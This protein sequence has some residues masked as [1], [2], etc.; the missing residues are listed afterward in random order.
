[1]QIWVAGNRTVVP[2]RGSLVDYKE[3]VR[4]EFEKEEAER[5]EGRKAVMEE[6]AEV[7]RIQR[8]DAQTLEQMAQK[9]ELEK[10]K[11]E[12]SANAL[13]SLLNSRKKSKTAKATKTSKQMQQ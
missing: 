12:E 11:E 2:F 3:M 13:A 10:K 8:A 6:K 7:K 1:M 9:K 5:L 4:A